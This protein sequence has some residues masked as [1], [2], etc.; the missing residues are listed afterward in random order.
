MILDDDL[1]SVEAM[2][3]ELGISQDEV[4]AMLQDLLAQGDLKGRITQD[5]KRFFREGIRVSDKPA[6]PHQEEEPA[7]LRFNTKP[8]RYV[9]QAGLVI[10]VISYATLILMRG[11]PGLEGIAILAMAL[12]LGLLL[13]GCYYIGL[14]KTP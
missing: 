9:A 7:F 4:R 3:A 2:S 8:A 5:G 14:R 11:N 6:I 10:L 12:G 1:S 13:G